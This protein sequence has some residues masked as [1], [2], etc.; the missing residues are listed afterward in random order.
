MVQP[1]S[2]KT[3]VFA[4]IIAII[5][6]IILVSSIISTISM[7]KYYLDSFYQS[8]F[9]YLLGV[10]SG[11]VGW[12][13]HFGIAL[14]VI[15]LLLLKP[16]EIGADSLES[17]NTVVS[18]GKLKDLSVLEWFGILILLAI[19]LV[20]IIMLLVWA[21]GADNLKK[22]FARANLLYVLIIAVIAIVV[23]IFTYQMYAY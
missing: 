9:T 11:Q 16:R 1:R 4:I 15:C 21:F 3:K 17:E 18:K 14:I 2:N 8:V 12:G 19:P 22:N 7:S 5:G 6:V 23:V 13:I 10:I 20:N